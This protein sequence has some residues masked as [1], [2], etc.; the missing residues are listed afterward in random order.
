M[1][2]LDLSSILGSTAGGGVVAVMAKLYLQRALK[3]LEDVVK[4]MV[5][6]KQELASRGVRLD[7]VE[8]NEETIRV[9]DRKI[10]ALESK[11]YNGERSALHG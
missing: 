5:E 1:E 10:A 11:V 4:T 6:I 3:D 9:H 8:R 2:H 7:R